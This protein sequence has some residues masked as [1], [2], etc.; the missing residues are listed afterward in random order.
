MTPKDLEI[1]ETNLGKGVFAKRPFEEGETLLPFEGK[2][3]HQKEIPEILQPEDDRYL[4]I[5]PT[6]YLGPSGGYDDFINHSCNPNSGVE[7]RDHSIQLKAI[8]KILL[9]EEITWDYSTTMD[10]NDWE[11]DCQCGSKNCRRRIQDF[12]KLPQ[13]TQKHYLQLGIVPEFISGSLN[14]GPV[15]GN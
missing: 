13:T 10:E 11:M 7:M 14:S 4:Q 9:G 5:G 2:I 6:E 15:I 8:K 3:L 1:R 12:K